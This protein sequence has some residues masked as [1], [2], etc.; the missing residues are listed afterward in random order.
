M[1]ETHNLTADQIEQAGRLL[2]PLFQQAVRGELH[3]MRNSFNAA[4]LEQTNELREI[5]EADARTA[6][7]R[8]DDH[9]RRIEAIEE[10]HLVISAEHKNRQK[11]FR[12]LWKIL[13]AIAAA[14]GMLGA[15]IG[16]AVN[17]A[18]QVYRDMRK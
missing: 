4:L 18:W 7:E 5:I 11:A 12:D 2:M 16:W 17:F 14:M 15:G 10:Q 6:K 3:E 13:A 1:P 9:E 8:H